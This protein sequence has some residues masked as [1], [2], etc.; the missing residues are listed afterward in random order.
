MSKTSSQRRNLVNEHDIQQERSGGSDLGAMRGGDQMAVESFWK[1][2][3]E[4]LKAK[5]AEWE[6]ELRGF[7]DASGYVETPEAHAQI[8][9][10]IARYLRR[11]ELMG[12]GKVVRLAELVQD[13]Y[14]HMAPSEV[15]KAVYEEMASHVANQAAALKKWAVKDVD[16]FV[17]ENVQGIAIPEEEKSWR[18]YE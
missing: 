1:E 3:L 6:P 14:P 5:Q 4:E 13:G 2:F 7:Q 9:I 8:Q 15:T 16:I 12:G 10:E 18:Q 17:P 11:L